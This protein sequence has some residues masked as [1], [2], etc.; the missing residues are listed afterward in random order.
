MVWDHGVNVFSK[1]TK[2][3][4]PINA[5]DVVERH[6]HYAQSIHKAYSALGYFLFLHK[7]HGLAMN[8]FTKQNMIHHL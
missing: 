4:T 3:T 6:N 7:G 5:K 1:Y 2:N 8:V